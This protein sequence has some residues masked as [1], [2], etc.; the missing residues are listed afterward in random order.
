[1][2]SK[3][4]LATLTAGIAATGALLAQPAEAAP[5]AAQQCGLYTNWA[6]GY[7]YHNCG[8]TGL[9]RVD[10]QPYGSQAFSETQCLRPGQE[11][12]LGWAG[13]QKVTVTQL[14]GP[15]RP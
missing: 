9:I 11:I 10:H 2:K 14:Q 6:G 4:A 5:M 8:G 13:A 1:M 7:Y 12:Y 15:C 3:F